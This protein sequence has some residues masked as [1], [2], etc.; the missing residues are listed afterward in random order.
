MRIV[1][2][3]HKW[4]N[5]NTSWIV[6][7]VDTYRKHIL[8]SQVQYIRDLHSMKYSNYARLLSMHWDVKYLL[9]TLPLRPMHSN[10]ANKNY[11]H[12]HIYIAS[13]RLSHSRL[14]LI[15][16]IIHILTNQWQ[17]NIEKHM[18]W[19]S[20]SLKTLKNKNF[21]K[22]IRENKKIKSIMD[23][24]FS[25]IKTCWSIIVRLPLKLEFFNYK[26]H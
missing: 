7:T 21:N 22:W 20:Y 9:P 25:I 10:I 18:M 11:N 23:I 6:C 17:Y 12:T 24:C 5:I 14:S 26:L 4:M 8:N 1:N 2:N 16:N 13:H 19:D 3:K 15:S